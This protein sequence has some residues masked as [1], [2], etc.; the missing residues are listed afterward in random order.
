M[1]ITFTFTK[2]KICLSKQ[3]EP[4]A[5]T[6]SMLPKL[7]IPSAIKT[8]KN[9]ISFCFLADW[10]ILGSTENSTIFLKYVRV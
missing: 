6:L 7:Y 8:H 10:A 9:V 4:C 3:N 1:P 5:L 2:N